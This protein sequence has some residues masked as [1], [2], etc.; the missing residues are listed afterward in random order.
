[1]GST[2]RL[3]LSRKG[4][5]PLCRDET[6]GGMGTT[7]AVEAGGERE[8]EGGRQSCAIAGQRRQPLPAA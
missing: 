7:S 1:M 3:I 2:K 5:W 4:T 6:A 8:R